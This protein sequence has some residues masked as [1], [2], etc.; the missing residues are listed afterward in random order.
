VSVDPRKTLPTKINLIKLRREYKTIKKI[1]GVL[2]EKRNALILYIRTLIN[3]YQKLHR[4]ASETLQRAYQEYASALLL[5]GYDN[6]RMAAELKKPSMYV[7]LKEKTVFAVRLPVIN[8]IAREDC[9]PPGILEYPPQ[10]TRAIEDLKKAFERYMKIVELETSI[11]KLI[12]E[13]RNTQR[14]MNSI[15]YVILPSYERTIKHIKLVLEERM[16]EEFMRLKV[17]KRRRE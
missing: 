8:L 17:L 1:R 12:N 16:R 6:A 10:F 15:D 7:S 2:E 9:E 14:L 4:E 5:V 3:D 13:L 11:R